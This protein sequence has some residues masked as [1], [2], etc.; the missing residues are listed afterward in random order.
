MGTVTATAGVHW[1]TMGTDA[2]MD[3][4]EDVFG[5]LGEPERPG[6]YGHPFKRVHESGAA[7]YC[8]SRLAGQPLV[9]N[10][11]GEVCET[12]AEPILVYSVELD[13]WLT[14][15]D[16]ALDVHPP[17]LARKR[18]RE[19]HRAFRA[20][21]CET[22][23]RRDSW[24][25]ITN[26]R[27]G[28]G[29]TLMLGGK[30]AQLRMRAYDR[31]GPLRIETQWRPER[32]VGRELP[33]LILKHGAGHWWRSTAAAVKFP[34]PWYRELLEQPAQVIP[35]VP[36]VGAAL[37][38]ALEQ[39]SQQWGQALWAF[40]MLGLGLEDLQRIPEALRGSQVA[41]LVAWGQAGKSLGY[42]GD[43]LITEARKLGPCGAAE[44]APRTTTM[45]VVRELCRKSK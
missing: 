1:L 29:W 44:Q 3:H 17:D 7:V 36:Q 41:K 27:A 14:R 5:G 26:S 9:V 2:P 12:W 37:A 43:R 30:T 20:G 10:V 32:D 13:A 24:D 35:Q 31:R 33:E 34:M 39:F 18:L 22:N 38:E 42:D 28:E 15:G 16:F 11:P 21:R 6:A 19:M 25:L 8:G 23:M 40:G 4:V 45:D